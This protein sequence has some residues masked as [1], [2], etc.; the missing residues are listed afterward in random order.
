MLGKEGDMD[1]HP[2]VSLLP[3]G[4]GIVVLAIIRHPWQ[5]A[6]RVMRSQTTTGQ[7]LRFCIVGSGNAA[8]DLAILNGLLLAIPTRNIVHL[9]I[10]N[11]FAVLVLQRDFLW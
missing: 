9:L 11:S 10:Y 5:V 8:L 2:L 1:R 7:F 6:Q 4:L 3:M